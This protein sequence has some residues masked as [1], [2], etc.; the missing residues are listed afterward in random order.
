MART[1]FLSWR[2][3]ANGS[4]WETASPTMSAA[5]AGLMPAATSFA[6]SAAAAAGASGARAGTHGGLDGG[7]R[8][9]DGLEQR[10]GGRGGGG[11][12]LGGLVGRLRAVEAG[13]RGG[14]GAAGAS[15]SI[16]RAA[17]FSTPSAALASAS[18]NGAACCTSAWMP[19]VARPSA[20]ARSVR[21]SE[22]LLVRERRPCVDLHVGAL[23]EAGHAA[24]EAL[25]AADHDGVGAELGAHLRE[26]VVEAAAA[27]GLGIGSR[28]HVQ[29]VLRH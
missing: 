1:S 15:S 13:G 2:V 21:S 27:E 8:L 23:E 24:R 3:A 26:H 16:S 10:L 28:I 6:S 11:R 14:D 19:G 5:S 18:E 22:R 9:D 12:E 20:V 29:S 4:A 7:G 17:A 25:A